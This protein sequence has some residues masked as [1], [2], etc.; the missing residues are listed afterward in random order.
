MP[1][2]IQQPT[3]PAPMTETDMHFN[4]S[5][6]VFIADNVNIGIGTFSETDINTLYANQPRL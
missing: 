5:L 4:A 6:E 3:Y 2:P 1:Q